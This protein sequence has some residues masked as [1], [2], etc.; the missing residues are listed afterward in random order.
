MILS[1]IVELLSIYSHQ[2]ANSSPLIGDL[3]WIETNK[4]SFSCI[5]HDLI[6]SKYVTLY[7]MVTIYLL[8][9]GGAMVVRNGS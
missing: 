7:Y 3:L 8:E 2:F 6:V 9:I 5:V 4:F 1:L